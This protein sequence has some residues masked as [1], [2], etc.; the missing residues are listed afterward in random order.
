M[1][2]TKAL[3]FDQW[4][5]NFKELKYDDLKGE[6][7]SFIQRVVQG[8]DIASD[9]VLASSLVIQNTAPRLKGAALLELYGGCGF[10][11]TVLQNMLAPGK[12]TVIERDDACVDHLK[13]E[14]PGVTVIKGS[15][16]D[17]YDQPADY[18][19][20]DS[21][22]WTINTMLKNPVNEQMHKT[23]FSYAPKAVQ[24][25]D[26][27]KSYLVANRDLYS[28]QLGVPVVTPKDYAKG[29][30]GLFFRK[31]GYNATAICYTRYSTYFMMEPG[32]H[33]A[34]EM[35][36]SDLNVTK[37]VKGFRWI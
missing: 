2:P 14:F 33:V 3:V 32:A 12:H 18:Y 37:G 6:K 9:C 25:W 16:E 13:R 36:T 5:L 15:A 8:G 34:V 30:S 23:I 27:S 26:S 29:L 10:Q 4:I 11:T 35:E 19:S 1:N 21:N 7:Q 28:K 17:Y 31:F 20:L 22:G 24:F